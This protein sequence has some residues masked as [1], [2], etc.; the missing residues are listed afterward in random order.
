ME[1]LSVNASVE[2]PEGFE[3]G[4]VTL[5]DESRDSNA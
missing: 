4:K 5:L 2:F 1:F 3:V